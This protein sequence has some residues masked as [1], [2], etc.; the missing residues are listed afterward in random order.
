[1]A[2]DGH[3]FSVSDNGVWLTDAVDPRYLRRRGG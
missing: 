2:A 1:M 3:A